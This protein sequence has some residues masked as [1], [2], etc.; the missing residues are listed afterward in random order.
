MKIINRLLRRNLSASQLAGF[1]LSNFVGMAILIVGVQFYEDVRSIWQSED[2]FIRKDYLVIN[3]KVTASN[4]MGRQSGGF[5]EEEIADLSK[6]PWV[7]RVGRFSAPDYRVS[8]SIGHGGRNISTDF[9]YESIPSDFIDLGD[10]PWG[11]APG[12]KEVPI[13][14]SKDYLTLYNFGFAASSGLP[15]MS[16]QM[17]SSIPL[18]LTVTGKN[19][20]EEFAGRVVGY[21]NRLNTILVPEDFLAFTESRYGS[22]RTSAPKRLIVDVSSPGDVAI[23]TYLDAHALE[24]AGDKSGSQASYLLNV[25]T[26]VMLAVGGVI[27]ILSFFILFLSVAL[28]MQK[29]RSKLHALIMLGYS[30]KDVGA[31]YRRL[32]AALSLVSW[33]MAVA[34][35][36]VLRG[37]YIG[38]IAGV[39]GASVSGIWIS[40]AAGLVLALIS[41]LINMIA[42]SSKVRS[43]FAA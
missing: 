32:V 3:K 39:E 7:R 14:I 33:V 23:Q 42:V 24:I 11:Y 27:T 31:P 9:F 21:S 25:V 4:T 41:A 29:N 35:M 17:M 36:L 12:A 8:A 30:L 5:S 10:A 2:S 20:S 38:R 22:G 15:Q 26:A 40:V 37:F 43:A 16:E 18:K 19:G 28:L 6:Q 1:V 13:I 34:V